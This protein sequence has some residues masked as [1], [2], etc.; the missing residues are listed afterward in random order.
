MRSCERLALEDS[1]WRPYEG[2][3]T[4]Q[5]TDSWEKMFLLHKR[6]LSW[7]TKTVWASLSIG[8]Q[9]LGCKQI[10]RSVMDGTKVWNEVPKQLIIRW[11]GVSFIVKFWYFK[12]NNSNQNPKSSESSKDNLYQKQV[13]WYRILN[14]SAEHRDSYFHRGWGNSPTLEDLVTLTFLPMFRGEGC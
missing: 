14:F 3:I 7:I 8:D 12:E 10:G 2:I 13:W 5:T 4:F 9:F 6:L 1:E 11:M